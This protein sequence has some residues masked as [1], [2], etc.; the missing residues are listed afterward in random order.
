MLAQ[1]AEQVPC[2]IVLLDRT[3]TVCFANEGQ[4]SL[5][6]FGVEEAGGL[7]AWLGRGC[8]EPEYREQV[9]CD[10][11]SNVWARQ[12]T[13][14]FSLATGEGL[15][16]EIELRP[17]L[18]HD[19]RLLLLISDVTEAIRH[20]DCL[21]LIEAKFR[22]LF[23][24][25][26]LGVLLLDGTGAIV[27]ANHTL[28]AALGLS[29]LELRRLGLEKLLAGTS[30]QAAQALHALARGAPDSDGRPLTVNLRARSG[31]LLPYEIT[32]APVRNADG[33]A[34]YSYL[35][36]S[37]PA[38]SGAFEPVIGPPLEGGEGPSAIAP[39]PDSR[40]EGSSTVDLRALAWHSLAAP[41][42]LTELRGR[43]VDLN[44]AAALLFGY[45]TE[46]LVGQG[47]FRIFSPQDPAGFGRRISEAIN[48]TRHWVDETD[49]VRADGSTGR[50]LAELYPV[51][52]AGGGPAVGLVLV[53]RPLQSRP[54][55]FTVVGAPPEEAR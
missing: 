54:S 52:P 35:F 12:L 8:L 14:T 7:E 40:A 53:A 9:L 15:L 38:A 5:L 1:V 55:P 41:A 31:E 16:K 24:D 21:R 51:H 17:R 11:R 32:A 27:E 2:G 37:P 45:A 29:R 23:Q 19:G 44:P 36:A 22:V 42:V 13:R 4:R 33:E 26:P 30:S 6:G 34:V 28:E 48:R 10:W 18:L 47:L 39:L 20:Q 25:C 50:C 3:G 46:E 43:V 49:F